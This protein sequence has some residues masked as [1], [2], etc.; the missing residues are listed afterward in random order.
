MF[1]QQRQLHNWCDSSL[2][3]RDFLNPWV[4]LLLSVQLLFGH[5]LVR[6][7]GF[8]C[9]VWWW[10]PHFTNTKH[11]DI[12]RVGWAMVGDSAWLRVTSSDC[13]CECM[14]NSAYISMN[15]LKK[16]VH[17]RNLAWLRVTPRDFAWLRVTLR[18]FAWLRVT[19]NSFLGFNTFFRPTMFFSSRIEK[20]IATCRVQRATWHTERYNVI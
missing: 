3:G 18:D 6:F 19:S 17:S 15:V 10:Q 7:W 2:L 4:S 16:W 11:V 13:F 9:G 5:H 12:V 8:S 1:V 14:Q 20:I